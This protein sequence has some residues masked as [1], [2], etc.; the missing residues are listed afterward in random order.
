M[1]D[2]QFPPL[3]RIVKTL[4]GIANMRIIALLLLHVY[5]FA[6]FCA[7]S[8]N[9]Q[10]VKADLFKKKFEEKWLKELA[11]LTVAHWN[12]Y[13][14]ESPENDKKM[15]EVQLK[16]QKYKKRMQERAKKIKLDNV[17]K[18]TKRYIDLLKVSVI[19]KDKQ[20]NKDK[21]TVKK[22]MSSIF[23]MGSFPYNAVMT[24]YGKPP[25]NGNILGPDLG[26][27]FWKS[28][29]PIELQYAW[30]AWRDA[31]GPKIKPKYTKYTR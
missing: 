22:D 17:D 11:E 3:C 1:F 21:E 26:G 20:L 9:G 6:S 24:S 23:R 14:Q 31:V 12:K 13:T 19:S 8:S 28:S 30:E 4:I 27:I 29:D 10:Q 16:A 7:E 2:F 5:L 18:T 25:A 15:T